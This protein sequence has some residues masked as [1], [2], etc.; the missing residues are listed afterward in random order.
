MGIR[1]SQLGG[2]QFVAA[3]APLL[4]PPATQLPTPISKIIHPRW[5]IATRDGIL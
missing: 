4:S 5:L 2:P 3:G 1:P